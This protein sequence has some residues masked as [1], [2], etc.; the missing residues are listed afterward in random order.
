ML[1]AAF[2]IEFSIARA[3]LEIV[4]LDKEMTKER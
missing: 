1:I 2:F 3:F 4:M